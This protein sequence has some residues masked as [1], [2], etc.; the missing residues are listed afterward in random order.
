MCWNVST[1]LSVSALRWIH[2]ER[3]K[4]DIT[5][6]QD[7]PIVGVMI[8]LG[9]LVIHAL[10]SAAET[11]FDAITGSL[12]RK[13]A[14]EGEERLKRLA[15]I[16]DR[17]KRCTTVLD[18]LRVITV[19]LCGITYAAL[20]REKF[21]PELT[22][23]F[24]PYKFPEA[25]L[26]VCLILFTVVFLWL[27]ELLAVKLPKKLAYKYAENTSVFLCGFVGVFMVLFAPM[28]YLAERAAGGLASLFG[29]RSG[30]TEENMTEEE[31]ISIVT[32]GQEQG[33]LEA[34]EAEMITNVMDFDEKA[35]KD[36]MTRRTN[37]V[38]VREEMSVE[39]ALEFCL[40]E[41]YSRLPI[42]RETIDDITGILYLRDLTVYYME[43]RNE[44]EL[45]K[46]TPLSEVAREPY[47]VPDTQNINVLLRD[48]QEK[49]VQMAIVIDEYGQTAGIVTMEDMLEEIV[50]DIQD[51]YD[52][53][54][55]AILPQ[56]DGAWLVR[57]FTPLEDLGAVLNIDFTEEAAD[58]LNGFLI[59]K[60]DRIP[61]EEET[62]Y[63]P[64]VENGYCYEIMGVQG[65][66]IDLVRITA[67]PDEPEE[68]EE[69]EE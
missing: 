31:I 28:A 17:R 35:A 52:E 40:H 13:R 11:A 56:E 23:T 1:R 43:Y 18:F 58:T 12:V 10:A 15:G 25:R 2:N 48:M 54:E 39:E 67:V 61:S 44:P 36:I 46:S 64:V 6:M 5:F 69:R 41:N 45:L 3:E 19:F 9:L 66:L 22:E 59:S 20:L 27:T 24:L 60:L 51:E 38:G 7:Y 14:A 16:L 65:K 53:E 63:P 33:L 21:V 50:G 49:K 57:G 42:Y 62:D 4:G 29:V 34:E 37:V 47:F 26:V 32:E 55:Q 30:D 68:P 8:I